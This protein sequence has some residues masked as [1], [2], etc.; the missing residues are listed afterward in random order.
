MFECAK[1]GDHPLT[2]GLPARVNIPH[3]RWNEVPEDI[4]TAAG[5][6][7][8]TKSDD[9]G[10][11][12]FVKQSRSLL[13][14]FQGNPEYDP[15]TLLLEYFSE[16]RETHTRAFLTV[17][18]TTKRLRRWPRCGNGRQPIV[19]RS[20]FGRCQQKWQH[21]GRGTHGPPRPLVS[22]ATGCTTSAR[23]SPGG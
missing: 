2:G 12:A 5:Y 13:V 4:L 15:D 22:I 19:A 10:V 18:S 23:K 8:L 17:T 14:F 21:A 9:A 7:I 1:E 6:R 20:C 11:D 3:S 16:E